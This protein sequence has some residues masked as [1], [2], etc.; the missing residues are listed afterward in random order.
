MRVC[1]QPFLSKE[2]GGNTLTCDTLFLV[3][4]EFLYVIL[5]PTVV[6]GKSIFLDLSYTWEHAGTTTEEVIKVPYFVAYSVPA[7]VCIKG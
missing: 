3:H 1:S 2:F 7:R 6:M 4:A 5:S